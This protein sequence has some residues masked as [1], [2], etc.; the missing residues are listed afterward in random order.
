MLRFVSDELFFYANNE[1]DAYVML[2]AFFELRMPIHEGYHFDPND[3]VIQRLEGGYY[4]YV[5]VEDQ[6]F[7]SRDFDML[8]VWSDVCLYSSLKNG[9]LIHYRI[10]EKT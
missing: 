7:T 6:D 10:E 5:S 2:K 8:L 3:I 4:F 9:C 1:Q